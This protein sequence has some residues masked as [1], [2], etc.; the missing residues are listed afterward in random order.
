[1]LT[2]RSEI[3]LQ[4]VLGAFLLGFIYMGV[5]RLWIAKTNAQIQAQQFR[6][7]L[8]QC[9]EELKTKEPKVK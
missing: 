2:S 4:V 1:M 9:S 8:Q 7:M 5:E 6:A 3:L